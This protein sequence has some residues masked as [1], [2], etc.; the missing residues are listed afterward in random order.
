MSR[1]QSRHFT[2]GEISGV[3]FGRGVFPETPSDT[4]EADFFR[5][6]R[7]AGIF[8]V[9]E[10][11]R[12]SPEGWAVKP[13]TQQNVTEV[14]TVRN[15]SLQRVAER[16]ACEGEILVTYRFRTG[17][18]G[19]ASPVGMDGARGVGHQS[20]WSAW[21]RKMSRFLRSDDTAAVRVSPGKRLRVNSVPDDIRQEFDVG[22]TENV[23]FVQL[24][25]EV[26]RDRDAIRFGN[27]RH[28]LLQR[29]GEGIWFEVLAD[30]S[31]DR[32]PDEEPEESHKLAPPVTESFTGASLR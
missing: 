29:F 9:M 3:D 5:R 12:G 15:I 31:N 22:V 11:N 25:A 20:W 8:H 4:E 10:E 2:L 7:I 14:C 23:N 27:G 19:L 21:K 18:V 30:G 24:N 13:V 17:S 26:C 28:I 16:L 6:F 1:S 32:Q